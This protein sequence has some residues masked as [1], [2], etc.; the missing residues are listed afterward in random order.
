[1]RFFNS[2]RLIQ[3]FS[4]WIIIKGIIDPKDTSKTFSFSLR[5]VWQKFETLRLSTKNAFWT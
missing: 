4:S 1:M 5:L 2:D 3:T